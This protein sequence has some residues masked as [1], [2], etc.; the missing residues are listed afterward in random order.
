V[1]AGGA[2]RTF[3][4]TYVGEVYGKDAEKMRRKMLIINHIVLFVVF[5]LDKIKAGFSSETPVFSLH[6]IIK[7][8]YNTNYSP[9]QR[10]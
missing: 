4:Y 2:G 6:K 7:S 3:T 10:R 8:Y 1:F 5:A 9:F